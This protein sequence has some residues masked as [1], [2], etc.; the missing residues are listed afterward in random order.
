M[1]SM[2]SWRRHINKRPHAPLST[3]IIPQHV[4]HTRD[5]LDVQDRRDFPHVVIEAADRDVL[6]SIAALL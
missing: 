2:T 1:T 4:S 5:K 6:A 3:S